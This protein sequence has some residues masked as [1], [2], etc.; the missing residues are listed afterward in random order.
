M[1]T[2]YLERITTN[3]KLKSGLDVDVNDF[4]SNGQCNPNHYYEDADNCLCDQKIKNCYPVKYQDTE[5]IMGSCCIKRFGIKKDKVCENCTQLYSTNNM[6]IRADDTNAS[7]CKECRD[8]VKYAINSTLRFGKHKDMSLEQ[9]YDQH[10]SYFSW[11]QNSFPKMATKLSLVKKYKLNKF[12]H[13]IVKGDEID[14]VDENDEIEVKFDFSVLD[15][16]RDYNNRPNSGCET[17]KIDKFNS[18]QEYEDHFLSI[19]KRH[20][21]HIAC[22]CKRVMLRIN[23]CCEVCFNEKLNNDI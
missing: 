12:C 14:K 16:V 20:P 3:L 15:A 4:F 7:L 13:K 11:L 8:N 1:N 17:C 10:P 9:I 21:K 19:R 5:Y 23:A 6:K 18:L 22:E 2:K